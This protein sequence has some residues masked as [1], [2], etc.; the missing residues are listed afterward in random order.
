MNTLAFDSLRAILVIGPA[1]LNNLFKTRD[2]LQKRFAGEAEEII[3][4]LWILEVNFQQSVI[5]H[6]QDFAILNAF[7][8]LR[9]S[10]VGRQEAELTHETSWRDLDAEL[11][12]EKFCANGEEHFI[13]RLSLAK[14]HV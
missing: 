6:R 7:D 5:G 1:L 4:E 9:P 10:I 11:G 2:I 12:H 14:Q 3:A 8:R 13:S